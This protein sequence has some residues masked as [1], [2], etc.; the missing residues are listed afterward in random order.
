VSGAA[1]PPERYFGAVTIE[2][3]RC[4]SHGCGG[5]P[6]AAMPWRTPEQP[7]PSVAWLCGGHATA[8][9]A[10]PGGTDGTV[11]QVVRTC[12]QEVER[13]PCGGVATHLAIVGVLGPAGQSLLRLVSVCERHLPTVDIR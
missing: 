12:Q 10:E 4:S 9:V 2:G 7:Q 1:V 13:V 8:V 11:A 3:K 6:V 5:V